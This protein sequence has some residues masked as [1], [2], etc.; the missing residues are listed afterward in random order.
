MQVLVVFKCSEVR[1]EVVLAAMWR[2]RV[3]LKSPI[4][5]RL[6]FAVHVPLTFI[7]YLSPLTCFKRFLLLQIETGSSFGR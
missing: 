2:R 1:P 5:T 7:V 6:R 3:N 4:E